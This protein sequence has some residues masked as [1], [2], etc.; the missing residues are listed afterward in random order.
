MKKKKMP[1][2][3]IIKFLFK[4]VFKKKMKAQVSLDDVY[5]QLQM[6]YDTNQLIESNHNVTI[7]LNGSTFKVTQKWKY[8]S[9]E[10]TRLVR[11]DVELDTYILYFTVAIKIAEDGTNYRNTQLTDFMSL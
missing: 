9:D 5:A 8:S 3:D 6:L 2:K 4:N 11:I 7:I 10:P 1:F